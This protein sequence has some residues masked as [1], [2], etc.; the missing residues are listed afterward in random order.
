LAKI[1]LTTALYTHFNIEHNRG[2]HRWV[3]TDRDPSSARPGEAL[4]LFWLRSVFGT[5]VNAWR[6]ENERLRQAGKPV[7]S[8]RNEMV[9]FQVAHLAYLMLVWWQFGWR[10]LGFAVAVAVVGIL[11]LETVNYIEH[12]GL[13]RKLLAS[14]HYETVSPRHSWNSNHD[15]GRIF[16]TN[17]PATATTTTRQPESTRCCG[18]STKAPN[19]LT[20][21]PPQCC[22]RW[23]RR[24]GFG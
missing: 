5:Y 23:C 11:L 13:R 1:L 20:A 18:I 17:S 21:T 7:F 2:H 19:S 3:G 12:Y 22:W 6:L 16:P 15:L 10:G 24:C 14:G 8:L 4:Y 9:W